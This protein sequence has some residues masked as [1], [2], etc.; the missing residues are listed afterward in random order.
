[1]CRLVVNCLQPLRK[2]T[3]HSNLITLIGK[4]DKN[5][6]TGFNNHLQLL[7]HVQEELL[8]ICD[9]SRGYKFEIYFFSK[10]NAG[11]NVICRILQM[12]PIEK[13]SNVEI[14][15]YGIYG[16]PYL[17]PIEAISNFLHRKCNR[18]RKNSNEIYLRINLAKIQNVQAICDH[19]RKVIKLRFF[20]SNL[21]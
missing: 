9:S 5:D 14:S 18:I 12:H 19:F 10:E 4:I 6:P 21:F 20:S 16:Q 17:L 11:S 3:N 7:N 8:S 13:C 2:A 1:M 15:L